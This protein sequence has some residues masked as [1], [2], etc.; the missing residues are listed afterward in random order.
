MPE[1]DS[2]VEP[3]NDAALVRQCLQGDNTA[4]DKLV[5][6]YQRQIYAFC[7]HMLGNYDDAVE[8]V[9]DTFVKAYYALDR[10]RQDANFRYWLFRIASNTCIDVIRTRTRCHVQSVEDAEAVIDGIRDEKLS[11]EDETVQAEERALLRHAVLGLSERYR[12]SLVMF[13]FNGMSIKEISQVLGRP[14]GTVKSDLHL[15]RE[16]LRR[17]LEGIMKDHGL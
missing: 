14:E 10:F 2:R 7:Y 13:H 16:M 8:A 1:E 3:R 12:L 4:F 17:R 15:A 6:R 11:P 5:K 9:Q